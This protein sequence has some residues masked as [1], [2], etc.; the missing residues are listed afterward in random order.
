MEPT[1]AEHVLE[2][3]LRMLF[4]FDL[5]E[6]E[7][8]QRILREAARKAGV[9]LKTHLARESVLEGVFARGDRKLAGVIEHA[10]RAGARFDS[11]EEHIKHELWQAALDAHGIDPAPYLGT[12]P[13]SARLPWGH[14]DVGLED[15][16]LAREYRKAL[17]S[18]LSPPCGKAAGMFVHHTNVADA[19]ADAQGEQGRTKDFIEGVVSFV[20]KRPPR[21]TG[22]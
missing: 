3:K 20:E 1:Q 6:V 21:F 13:V 17:R 22:T 16:F 9:E 2:Q 15:G 19:E 8:K 7:R 10:W 18:K 11:W 5:D 12:L 14:I 4:N